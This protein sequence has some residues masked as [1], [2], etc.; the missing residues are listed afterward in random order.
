MVSPPF[1]PVHSLLIFALAAHI[2][3]LSSEEDFLDIIYLGIFVILS[4]AFDRRF[5]FKPSPNLVNELTYAIQNFQ[6]LFHVFSLRFMIFVGGQAVAASYIQHRMLA[7]FAAAAV[8]LAR[9]FQGPFGEGDKDGE[10][11]IS[12]NRFQRMVE[13]IILDSCVD[14]MPFFAS[15][16]DN[17]HNDFLWSGPTITIIPRSKDVISVLKIAGTGELLDIPGC[18]IYETAID[19]ALCGPNPPPKKRHCSEDEIDNDCK[20]RKH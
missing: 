16:T 5:Y 7:E 8:V 10:R 18:T 15:R 19:D 4:P 14:L 17:D 20:R 2:P 13:G 3:S 1:T 9:S 6:S 12:L 11:G